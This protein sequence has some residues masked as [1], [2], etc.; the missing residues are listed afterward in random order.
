VR[1]EGSKDPFS[2]EERKGGLKYKKA[3]HDGMLHQHGSVMW[4]THHSTS[5]GIQKYIF[6]VCEPK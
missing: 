6:K 4:Q 2:R 5:L 3:C 1:E